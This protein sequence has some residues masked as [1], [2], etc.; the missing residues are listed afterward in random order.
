MASFTS[1]NNGNDTEENN[2]IP[3]AASICVHYRG[4]DAQEGTVADDGKDSIGLAELNT[5]LSK[6]SADNPLGILQS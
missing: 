4:D 5:C 1:D 2:F 3:N 6:F